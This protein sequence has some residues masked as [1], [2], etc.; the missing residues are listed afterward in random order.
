MTA[1]QPLKSPVTIK[2]P[3][4]YFAIAKLF[5]KIS[6]QLEQAS[7]AASKAKQNQLSIF[8]QESLSH[9]GLKSNEGYAL[10]GMAIVTGATQITS[11]LTK[12]LTETILKTTGACLPILNQ[13]MTSFFGSS[14]VM[15]GSKK[16]IANIEADAQKDI[17]AKMDHQHDQLIDKAQNLTRIA[18][19]MKQIR[20]N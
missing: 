17:S 9:K 11:Q 7:F 15:Y 18:S 10:I 5:L 13:G 1:I 6:H 14:E 12:G 3:I 16:Q 8:Q 19:S 20:S 4:D 2:S